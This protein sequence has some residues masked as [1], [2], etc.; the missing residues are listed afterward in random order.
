MTINKILSIAILFFFLTSCEK[1]T[2]IEEATTEHESITFGGGTSDQPKETQ[3]EV[4]KRMRAKTLQFLEMTGQSMDLLTESVV[5]AK[6]I[7]SAYNSG[8]ITNGYPSLPYSGLDPLHFGTRTGTTQWISLTLDNSYISTT[9]DGF[10]NNRSGRV[11]FYLRGVN[12]RVSLN[13]SINVGTQNA[14]ITP[15]TTASLHSRAMPN[16]SFAFGGPMAVT[17]HSN[18]AGWL[19]IE[20]KKSGTVVFSSLYRYNYNTGLNARNGGH[21]DAYGFGQQL[22]GPLPPW[23]PAGFTTNYSGYCGWF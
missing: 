2:L 22:V 20:V 8:R 15:S 17:I 21:I 18:T 4:V 12:Q 3:E 14:V 23:T 16:T 10:T 9:P 1:E 6:A 11:N 5:G 13:F 7:N 19:W